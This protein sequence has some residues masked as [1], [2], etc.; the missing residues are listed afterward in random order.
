LHHGGNTGTGGASHESVGG[1]RFQYPSDFLSCRGLKTFGHH[2]H[3]Q[4]KESQPAKRLNDDA[5]NVQFFPFEC[6]CCWY[7]PKTNLTKS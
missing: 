4:N 2:F 6:G 3:S 1:E 7:C 5:D